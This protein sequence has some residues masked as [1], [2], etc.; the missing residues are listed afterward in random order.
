MS[1]KPSGQRTKPQRTDAPSS[2]N[3]RNDVVL[4]GRMSDT[5]VER[6]LPSGDVLVTFRVVVDRPDVPA[7]AVSTPATSSARPRTPRI[8]ALDCVAWRADVRRQVL[9]YAPGDIVEVQGSLRRRFWRG[10]AGAVSR[11]EVEVT[12]CRRV[13]KSS[14]SER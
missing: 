9:A 10:G 13:R 5:A 4:V 2:E 14:P 1:E 8:D 12:R 3:H 11:S 7:K 6:E